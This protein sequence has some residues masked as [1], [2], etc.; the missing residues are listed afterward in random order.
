M[1]INYVIKS[2]TPAQV[3]SWLDGHSNEPE[4]PD[5]TLTQCFWITAGSSGQWC[6]EMRK[7]SG[8]TLVLVLDEYDDGI[9]PSAIRIA[10]RHIMQASGQWVPMVCLV[11]IAPSSMVR[12]AVW[13]NELDEVTAGPLPLT[14]LL[15]RGMLYGLPGIRRSLRGIK[16]L[17]SWFYWGRR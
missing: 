8:A 5:V 2:S 7:K 13:Q 12:H 16:R 6:T 11:L 1:K 15:V 17:A 10:V 14:Y 9:S 4:L 3:R